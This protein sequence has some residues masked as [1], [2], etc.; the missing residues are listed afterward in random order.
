MYLRFGRA[1]VPVIN[2]NADYKFEI[3][4]AVA[5]REGTDVTII[6]TGLPVSESL[7]AAEKLAAEGISAEVINCLLY[8]SRCV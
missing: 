1:A 7:A 5:L 6:A 2:D 8:T 3:G 4:K